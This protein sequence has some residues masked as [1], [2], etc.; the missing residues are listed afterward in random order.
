MISEIRA[1][2]PQLTEALKGGQTLGLVTIKQEKNPHTPK[3]KPDP[4]PT[5]FFAVT[6]DR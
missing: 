4:P 1:F 2:T 3:D 6:R 5:W